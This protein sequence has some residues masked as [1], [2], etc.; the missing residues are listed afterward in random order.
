ME[1]SEPTDV[2]VS[3]CKTSVPESLIADELAIPGQRHSSER[4]KLKSQK[5]CTLLLYPVYSQLRKNTPHLAAVLP[6]SKVKPQLATNS[7]FMKPADAIYS[8]L[9]DSH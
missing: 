6:S 3:I 2:Y 5:C 8:G 1:R 7:S 4:H 9:G